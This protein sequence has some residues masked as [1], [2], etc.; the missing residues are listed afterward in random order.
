MHAGVWETCSGRRLTTFPEVVQGNLEVFAFSPDG[1]LLAC[2]GV[3]GRISVLDFSGRTLKFHFD[4][5]PGGVLSLSF[6]SDGRR[7]VSAANDATIRVW[8]IPSRQAVGNRVSMI[9]M[10]ICGL[11]TAAFA[12]SSRNSVLAGS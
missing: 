5:H 1:S 9:G 8:D 12:R 6:S 2:S 10:C 4:G 11:K 7:L 3:Q